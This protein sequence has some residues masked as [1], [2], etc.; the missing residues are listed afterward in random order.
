MKTASKPTPPGRTQLARSFRKRATKAEAWLWGWLK[1]RGLGVKFRRQVPVGPY[2]VDFLSLEV[3]LIVEVDGSQH[4]EE[5]AQERDRERD[6][7]LREEGYEVIHFWGHDILS[8]MEGCLQHLSEKTEA[9]RKKLAR[10]PP[11]P[12]GRRKG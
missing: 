3:K 2:I 10:D 7:F 1:N 11:S 5:R 8:N 6:Q 4:G 9:Q 12:T